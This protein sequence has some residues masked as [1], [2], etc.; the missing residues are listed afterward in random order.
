MPSA[1][2]PDKFARLARRLASRPD[3]SDHG[4]LL[5]ALGAALEVEELGDRLARVVAALGSERLIV[6]VPVEAHPDQ[7]GGEHRPQDLDPDSQIPLA[8]DERDG[9]TAIAVFSSAEALRHWDREARPLALTSQKV[10]I[11][12]IATGVP[13]LRLDPADQSLL[14][15]RPAVEALAAG[16]R[17]LPGWEDE[18]LRA[19]LSARAAEL[20]PWASFVSVTLRPNPTGLTVEVSAAP[21]E[22]H[23]RVREDFAALLAQ[24]GQ[25]P[26]LGAA[27]ESVEFNP[28]LV[29][30]A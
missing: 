25:D 18:L 30:L 28:R 13:R 6:P 2:N 4:Q 24:L 3:R 15:S 19:H 10:A 14:L 12:A 29:H 26:R 22:G 16:D 5:P 9:V 21:R 27:A 23:R 20:A 1:L 8:T 17:W 7:A 11:T